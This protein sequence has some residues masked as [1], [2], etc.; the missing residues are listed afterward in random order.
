MNL[1][2]IGSF[3]QLKV[4]LGLG[5][6]S[7]V[8]EPGGHPLLL[9]NGL[10][11]LGVSA[12]LGLANPCVPLDLR[13]PG[14]PQGLEVALLVPDVLE[15][16]AYHGDPH[17]DQVRARHLKHCLGELLSVPVDLLHSHGAHDGPLVTLQSLQG[18]LK[19][20]VRIQINT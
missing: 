16:V 12:G 15:G 17:V 1:D 2:I 10:L 19:R 6:L 3:L 8:E 20:K 7:V 4:P 18:N 5:N 9:G 13:S 11:D 14:Q